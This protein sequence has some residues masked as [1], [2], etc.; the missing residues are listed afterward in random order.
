MDIKLDTYERILFLDLRPWLQEKDN[1]VK[2]IQLAKE[3]S[4]E[5]YTI[6][7]HHEVLFP[8]PLLNIRK[9]YVL[10]IENEAIRF[11][12]NFHSEVSGSMNKKEK[13]YYVNITITRILFQKLKETNNVIAVRN[14]TPD[15]FD[16]V[17]KSTP[18]EVALATESYILHYLKHQLVRLVIEIQDCYPE[19]LKE[20]PLTE[21]EIYFRFFHEPTPA[22]SFIVKA[23]NYPNT[24]QTISLIPKPEPTPFKALQSDFRPEKKGIRS[25]KEMIKNPSRFASFE[26]KLYTE[27]FINENYQFQDKHG[28]KQFLAAI[29]H[30]LINKGFFCTY[31]FPGKIIVTHLA[32]RKFLDYR[33]NANVDKQF[34]NWENNQSSLLSFIEKY[35]W[36]DNISP[37]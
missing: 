37:C 14:Y 16:P 28:Q 13:T 7:P 5:H 9:F 34:R 17:N 2:Y 10:I 32:I 22:P 11:L 26:D 3:L 31:F 21:D 23:A 24:K 12:N 6:Q 20:Y 19:Y 4:R 30:Q 36:L 15:Q 1:E 18:E 27:G 35:Y 33:Y 25:Y 8:K 29:Y